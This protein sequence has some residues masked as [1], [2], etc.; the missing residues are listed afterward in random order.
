VRA[1]D[2]VTQLAVYLP[3]FADDF[4]TQFSITSLTRSGT[5]VTA[6]TSAAH[7]LA[8]GQ[9]INIVGA[10]TPIAISSISRSG[11]VAT[12]VTASDHDI[13]EN[14]GFSVEI[15]GANEAEF[16]GT[17][18]LVSVPNRRT[19]TFKVADSGPTSATGT[20]LLLNGANP[21][22]TYNG[23]REITATPTSTS[24]QYEI[25]DATLY[26]PA[27]GTISAKTN[28]RISEAV[29]FDRLIDAYTKRGNGEAWLFVVMGDAVASK[30]RNIDTDSTDNIQR[31]HY[32][33]QRLIQNVQLFVFLPTSAEISGGA[34]RDR[35]EELLKP[36]CNSILA[37]KFPSLVENKNNP[38]MITSHGAQAYSTAFYVHQYSFEATIQL[39]PSD[40][41]V[42]ADDVAFRDIDLTMGLD[43]GTETF[44][45][46]IDLDDDPL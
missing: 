6:T 46:L 2:I 3:T 14:A 13:T 15:A 23:L 1:S 16:N 35:C 7:S 40:I 17:F 25:S 31:G 42:P 32:F 30:S 26:T 34:A 18:E 43:V 45:T 5:T 8:V 41:F 10:Q 38:L 4:T 28:P 12:M 27:S 29:D 11:I 44:N 9:Q 33:N 19:I 20:P 22:Q 37:V 21:Y 36:I 24:F 39:G